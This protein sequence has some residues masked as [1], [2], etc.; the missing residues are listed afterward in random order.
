MAWFHH[1]LLSFRNLVSNDSVSIRPDSRYR[2]QTAARSDSFAPADTNPGP[3][4][5]SEP[6]TNIFKVSLF[7]LNYWVDWLIIWI[8]SNFY[9][10]KRCIVLG[11]CP[12]SCKASTI[13]TKRPAVRD[14]FKPSQ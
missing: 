9:N 14:S 8:A 11:F 2:T 10:H 13:K 7:T 1:L 5:F 4:A 3:R 12:C 6:E